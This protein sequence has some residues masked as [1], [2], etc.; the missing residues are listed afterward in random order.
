MLLMM[1]ALAAVPALKCPRGFTA[2]EDACVVAQDKPAPVVV[3][4]HGVLP[5][6]TDFA[7]VREW[8]LLGAE[9]R[10]RGVTLVVL[11]GEQGLCLWQKDLWCWPN[12]LSQVK[13]VDRVLDRVARA[14]T[15]LSVEGA[16]V[17]A[18]FSNGGYLTAMIASDTNA[19][20]RAYVVM[21]AGNVTGEEF[22]FSRARPVLVLGASRDP[23]QLPV[24]R[25]F[26]A[27]LKDA[28]WPAVELTVREGVH[29]VTPDDAKLLF[30]FV[31]GLR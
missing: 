17:F 30:K 21:H 31:A 12:D 23:I 20:A 3:Y 14:L 7:H 25:R 6:A 18:G 24:A 1:L 8:V 22:P 4:F 16:P 9:A 13:D 5:A 10:R 11:R 19:E 26:A 2:L 29:E 28:K 15:Q 27:M